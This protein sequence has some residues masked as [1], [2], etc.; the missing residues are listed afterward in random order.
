MCIR[1]VA[2]ITSL[3]AGITKE[4]ALRGLSGKFLLAKSENV[5]KTSALENTRRVIKKRLI[6]K[7]K[8][9]RNLIT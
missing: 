3:K 2:S 1:R 6:R 8:R 7:D 5:D 9:M 4:N